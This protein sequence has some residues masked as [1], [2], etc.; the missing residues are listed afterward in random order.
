[1][2]KKRNNLHTVLIHEVFCLVT[3]QAKGTMGAYHLLEL[4]SLCAVVLSWYSELLLTE[5]IILPEGGQLMR[6][7]SSVS[8]QTDLFHLKAALFGQPVLT[9]W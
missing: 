6:C 4:I 3:Q 9:K 7:S 2:G 5:P 1:M 8:L